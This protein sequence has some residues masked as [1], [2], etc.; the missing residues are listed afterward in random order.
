MKVK[1]RIEVT[2]V[3]RDFAYVTV[4]AD[5]FAEARDKAGDI[6]RD[7]ETTLGW[8]HSDEIENTLCTDTQVDWK[9]KELESS[10][11]C[12]Y[13][14]ALIDESMLQEFNEFNLLNGLYLCECGISTH[15]VTK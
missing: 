9:C 4:E 7:G 5:N 14:G 8:W 3:S 11:I 1:V 2:T 12:T 13:C 10:F 15:G 6:Y